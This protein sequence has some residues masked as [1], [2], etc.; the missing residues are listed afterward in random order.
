MFWI[1]LMS[2]TWKSNVLLVNLIIT[3]SYHCG[4]SD[5]AIYYALS[6]FLLCQTVDHDKNEGE[7]REVFK[8]RVCTLD[9]SLCA[10]LPLSPWLT[11]W[12]RSGQAHGTTARTTITEFDNTMVKAAWRSEKRGEWRH[13]PPVDVVG[14]SISQ[15][16]IMPPVIH[17]KVMYFVSRSFDRYLMDNPA[18]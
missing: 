8:S 1:W 11:V 13:A 14:T 5:Y 2:T 15:N 18:C 6:A 9:L 10:F 17:L 7:D 4:V 3:R 16:Q 12:A